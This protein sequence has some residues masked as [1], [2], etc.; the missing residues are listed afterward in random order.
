MNTFLLTTR[1]VNSLTALVSLIIM[2]ALIRNRH[3][4]HIKIASPLLTAVSAGACTVL[5][6]VGICLSFGISECTYLNVLGHISFYLIISPITMKNYRLYLIYNM[7][8]SEGPYND[9][10]LFS[11][12]SVGLFF[13]VLYL[14]IW[15]T[16]E[17]DPCRVQ[18]IP[19]WLIPLVLDL[20]LV[21]TTIYLLYNLIPHDKGHADV[22]PTCISLILISFLAMFVILILATG[23]SFDYTPIITLSI[24]LFTASA[25]CPI[26]ISRGTVTP[27]VTYNVRPL[28]T[29]NT[30]F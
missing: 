25:F 6:C 29:I 5:S 1:I 11:Y 17:K 3:L 4:P 10:R 19:L 27:T 21:I 2:I 9:K 14:Y 7:I 8:I 24:I 16:L 13:L 20:G 28:V 12:V 30:S 15:M 22:E 18:N 23:F 26:L